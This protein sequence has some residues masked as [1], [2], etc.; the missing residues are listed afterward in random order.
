MS[1]T[2]FVIMTGTEIPEGRRG[3]GAYHLMLQCH[4]YNDF[5]NKM[6]SVVSHFNV[7]LIVQGKG[8]RQLSVHKPQFVN[9]KMSQSES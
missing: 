6:G 9:R 3:E 7:S 1:C 4:H 5:S 8:T 2:T